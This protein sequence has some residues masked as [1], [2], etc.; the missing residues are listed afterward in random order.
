MLKPGTMLTISHPLEMS[1]KQR[2]WTAEWLRQ[3][4]Q[5]LVDLV[6]KEG[7]IHKDFY[8]GAYFY[9]YY[10]ATLEKELEGK[11]S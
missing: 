10:V 2:T 7:E 1:L 11:V 3:E 4:A 5:R 8:R 9:D 6:Y